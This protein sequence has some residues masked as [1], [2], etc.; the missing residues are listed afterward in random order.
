MAK[1][2]IPYQLDKARN[3][4]YGMKAFSKIEDATGKPLA[5][6][7]FNE[8]SMKDLAL[9][10]WAGLV[11]EDR[12][13]TVEKTMELIDDY[14]DIETAAEMLGKAITESMGG[15]RMSVPG[16]RGKK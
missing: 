4:R 3:L 8:L 2:F 9:I 15:T 6:I 13:L 7:D 5:K 10:I 12:E 1:A 16:K 11:H 14:S